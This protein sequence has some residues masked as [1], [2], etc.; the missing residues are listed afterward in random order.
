MGIDGIRIRK[1]LLVMMVVVCTLT[2]STSATLLTHDHRTGPGN[3]NLCA[4]C[5]LAWLQPSNLASLLPPAMRE[6]RDATE[7]RCRIVDSRETE[8]P[9]RAPPA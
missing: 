8:T 1:L 7:R 4:V 5:H 6:W 3:C 2:V 9:S